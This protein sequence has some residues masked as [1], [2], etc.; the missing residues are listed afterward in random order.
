MG[1]FIRMCDKCQG[2]ILASF[3]ENSDNMLQTVG[4]L[5]VLEVMTSLSRLT[6]DGLFIPQ[7]GL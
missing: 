7:V 3:L 1:V 5:G 6:A 4:A 2:L